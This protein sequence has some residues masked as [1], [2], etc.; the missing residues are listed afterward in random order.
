MDLIGSLLYGLWSQPRFAIPSLL[1]IGAGTGLF[2]LTG[3]EPASA[4]MAVGC[5]LLGLAIGFVLHYVRDTPRD[6]RD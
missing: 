3:K 5:V 4:A 1:G 2:F 6:P